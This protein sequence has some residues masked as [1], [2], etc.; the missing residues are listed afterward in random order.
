MK[1]A[2]H[3]TPVG[4]RL[5]ARRAAS[6]R[7]PVLECG[8]SDPWSYGP[9]S[10]VNLCNALHRSSSS[11]G[12][13]AAA[14]HLLEH[15][16]TPAPNLPGD[17]EGRRAESPHSPGHCRAVGAGRMSVYG[18]SALNGRRYRRTQ[19]ELAEID[20]AIYAIADVERPCTVRGLFYRV[21]SKGLV[22]KTEQG[23][24]AVQR[25]ALKMRVPANCRTTGSLTAADCG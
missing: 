16:L 23:Y 18:T 24:G 10:A 12:Y 8:R 13:V 19:A 14:A 9:P 3:A 1:G 21:M 2:F 22:P 6:Y 11:D 17:V 4:R 25:Q 20:A 15:G 5:H 7:L